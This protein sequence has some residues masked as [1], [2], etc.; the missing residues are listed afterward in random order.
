M[1]LKGDS[2]LH[3]VALRMTDIYG[4]KEWGGWRHSL[5]PPLS[6]SLTLKSIVILSEAKNLIIIVGQ[7]YYF[8]NKYMLT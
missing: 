2:S 5:H 1:K 6:N 3:F 7:Y 4:F 8:I